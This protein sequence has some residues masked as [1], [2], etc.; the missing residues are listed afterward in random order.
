MLSSLDTTAVMMEP[1]STLNMFV[2]ELNIVMEEKM[3]KIV[4]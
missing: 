1:A 4:K 3:R 2:M